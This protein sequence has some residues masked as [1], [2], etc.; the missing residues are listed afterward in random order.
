MT[1]GGTISNDMLR[2]LT[3]EQRLQLFN[4]FFSPFSGWRRLL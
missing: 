3:H 1:D 2:H 4:E